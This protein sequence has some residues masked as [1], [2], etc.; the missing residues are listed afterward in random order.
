MTKNTDF[1]IAIHQ[2]FD[3]INST[4]Q[5]SMVHSLYSA[6][7]F[8]HI[9]DELNGVMGVGPKRIPFLFHVKFAKKVGYTTILTT[10][11]KHSPMAFL[12]HD[13]PDT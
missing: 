2:V 6:K 5:Q 1:Y 10:K 13:S 11:P 7:V 3:K 12:V 4:I 9:L 8:R